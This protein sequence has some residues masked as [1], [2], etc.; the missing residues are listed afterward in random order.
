MKF[1]KV[2]KVLLS[3]VMAGALFTGCGGGDKPAAESP[4]KC[5]SSSSA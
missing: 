5:P 4:L 2:A 1:T 3:C